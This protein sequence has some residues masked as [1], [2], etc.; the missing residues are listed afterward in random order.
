VLYAERHR[1]AAGIGWVIGH[2]H[3]VVDA[4]LLFVLSPI[5]EIRALDAKPR[6][7]FQ[8]KDQSYHILESA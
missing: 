7:L 8:S 6:F 5:P 2:Q 3:K 1:K 4:L